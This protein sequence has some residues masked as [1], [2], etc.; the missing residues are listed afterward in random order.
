MQMPAESIS[1]EKIETALENLWLILQ[2]LSSRGVP[3]WRIETQILPLYQGKTQANPFPGT[4]EVLNANLRTLTRLTGVISS[5]QGGD[6]D[7]A[8]DGDLETA[9]TQT[10]PNGS[11]ELD[12]GT[13]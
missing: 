7:L 12:L 3:V 6:P 10:A 5:D 11:L 4:V 2:V 1:G 13:A 8:I 9:C